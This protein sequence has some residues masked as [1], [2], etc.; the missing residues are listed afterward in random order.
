MVP[1]NVVAVMGITGAGKSS[2]IKLVTSN[3]TIEIAH[4]LESG[5]TKNFHKLDLS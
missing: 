3:Q 2:F 4:R 5:K 1:T